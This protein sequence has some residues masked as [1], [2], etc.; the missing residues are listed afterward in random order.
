MTE[1]W[2]PGATRIPGP[3][4]KQGYWGIPSRS[5]AQIEA[6]IKH[7]VEGTWQGA[8]NVLNGGVTVSWTFLVPRAPVGAVRYAQHYP[9]E[10]ITYHAGVRGD[11][12]TVTDLIGNLTMVGIEH[13]GRAG[14]PLTQ[15]QLDVTVE[16]SQFLR[17][18]TGAGNK[19]PA[20]RVNLY[21]HKWVRATACPSDRVQWPYIIDKL[22]P[23]PPPP[24]PP[25]PP[26]EEQEVV[27]VRVRDKRPV[28]AFN[29]CYFDHVVNGDAATAAYGK[30]WGKKVV[31]IEPGDKGNIMHP[32]GD[33]HLPVHYVEGDEFNN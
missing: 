3:G 28:F 21:E 16:I 25:P 18:H 31:I 29:G 19:P 6:E 14:Q 5:L 11:M 26:E 20:L 12:E 9:L 13:A 23:A 7:S 8:L 1:T 30:D 33:K 10:S 15:H 32:Y 4:W 17:D 24:P 27:L 22:T 2:I